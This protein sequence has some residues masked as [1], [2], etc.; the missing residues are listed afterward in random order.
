VNPSRTSRRWLI[1][2]LALL[3]LV[4][5]IAANAAGP[6]GTWSQFLPLASSG[7]SGR[8]YPTG[9]YDPNSASLLIYGGYPYARHDLWKF[10]LGA[11]G[12]WT[13]LGPG[14]TPND[15]WGHAAV[16]DPVRNRMIVMG[17]FDN[18]FQSNTVSVLN[19]TGPQSWSTILPA[20][21]PPAA[22]RNHTMLYDPVRDRLLVIGGYEGG[23][24]FGNDVWALSLAGPPVWT[25]LAPLG[26]LPTGRSMTYAVYDPVGDR[27]VMFG[28]WSGTAFL[29]DLWQLSLSGAPTWSI[30]PAPGF[31][32][33]TRRDGAAVYDAANNRIVY[34]G[35]L[36]GSNPNGVLI[37]QTWALSLGGTP[38]W[39]PLSPSGSPPTP[40]AS[41]GSAYDPVGN[42]LIVF[43]GYDGPADEK[44][45]WALSLGAG[46][47]TWTQLFVDPGPANPPGNCDYAM[48]YDPAR[49]R[50]VYFGGKRN[51]QSSETWLWQLGG[52]PAFSQLFTPNSP[53]G[54]YSTSG[55]FDVPNDRMLIFGGYDV[56]QNYTNDVWQL[57]FTGPSNWTPVSAIGPAPQPRLYNTLITDPVRQ[58]MV[59][60]GGNNNVNFQMNDVW[61]LPFSG[62]PQWTQ[63]F[64]GG[65]LPP[66]RWGHS[67]VYD[68]VRDE[69]ITF[70]GNGGLDRNDLWALH[71]SPSPTWVQLL[72]A[73]A[74]PPV[75]RNATLVY[76]SS[77]DRVL[78]FGGASDATGHNVFYYDVWELSLA[79]LQWTRLTPSGP[80]PENRDQ[81]Q[82]IYEPLLDRMAVYGGWFAHLQEDAWFLTFDHPTAAEV[83]LMKASVTTDGVQIAW[84]IGPTSDPPIAIQRSTDGAAWSNVGDVTLASDRTVSWID[85]DA[86]RGHVG[87][88]LA[89]RS[90]SGTTYSGEA[91]VDVG[92]RLQFGIHSIGPNP[93]VESA[94]LS[95]S[96]ARR[97]NASV[98]LIDVS[99]RRVFT[100]DLGTLEA[101]NHRV[102]LDGLGRLPA[103]LYMVRVKSGADAG[104]TR[105][106]LVR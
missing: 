62:P 103:G 41:F 67:S 29:N 87:Y 1:P 71:F 34:F 32:P 20:G 89:F 19:L 21:A 93:A 75:R 97:G 72:P 65:P 66:P 35:G 47:E 51:F 23:N 8:V 57:N 78:L 49:N 13:Q 77:R 53:L 92:D 100:R 83:S 106:M 17:G 11:P 73:G 46:S 58:R 105:L 91:W 74:P 24:T 69:M 10:P 48:A 22:R 43:G 28:G 96:L 99:G 2:L 42:R 81:M 70:G 55:T 76:D 104:S 16:Y 95:L 15:V 68:P 40:R 4:P 94:V 30:L 12:N 84:L 64:P 7:P 37:N 38:S 54:R 88:R 98:D 14:G 45:V 56:T 101:G 3:L 90:A 82:A 44:D 27:V 59:M 63:I 5:A 102:P 26:P 85:T 52:A 33:S 18:E 80:L 61:V 50:A 9:I 79:P 31:P 25:H 39:S 6:S 60:F 36:E 86:P